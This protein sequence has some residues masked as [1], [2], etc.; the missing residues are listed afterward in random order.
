VSKSVNLRLK[1]ELIAEVDEVADRMGM[2]RATLVR[3]AV[4]YF[5]SNVT[6]AAI[7]TPK[8]KDGFTKEDHRREIYDNERQMGEHEDEREMGEYDDA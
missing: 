7:P 2:S 4:K 3:M 5:L 1:L 8:V 6:G